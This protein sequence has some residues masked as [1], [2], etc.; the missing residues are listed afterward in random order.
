MNIS[1]FKEV[2]T[3]ESLAAL[4]KSAETYENLYVEMD[5]PEQRKFVKDSA[6]HISVLIKKIDRFRIDH[7]RD[8][9]V[10]VDSEAA[11]ITARLECANK[12]FTLLIDEYKLVREKQIS[13]Q[14]AREAAKQLALQIPIDH[15]DGLLM[16]KMF[17]FEKDEIIR[18]QQSRDQLIANE[19]AE[20]ERARSAQALIDAEYEKQKAERQVLK[21]QE[22]AKALKL[23]GIQ[24]AMDAVEQA[25]VDQQKALDNEANRLEVIRIKYEA[26]IARREA[27]KEHCRK[28]NGE[29]VECLRH[30]G[31]SNEN[32]TLAVRLIAAKRVTNI[33]INY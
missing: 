4:E 28:L 24:D 19:A 2:T 6:S 14:K 11:L 5:Q 29:A 7:K 3:E 10:Q 20:A 1:I 33:V 22:D 13:K 15:D 12:P 23:Q 26:E 9:N 18:E 25:K 17:D 21:Q 8:H 31:L 16:N 27:N 30:G 32:A